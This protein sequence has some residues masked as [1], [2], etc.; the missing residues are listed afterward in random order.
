MYQNEDGFISHSCHLTG[1][2]RGALITV[3]GIL[4]NPQNREPRARNFGEGGGGGRNCFAE[5]LKSTFVEDH[6]TT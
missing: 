4:E 1:G 6:H 2:G 5:S 3:K